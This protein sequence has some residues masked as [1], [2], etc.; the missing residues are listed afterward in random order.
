MSTESPPELLEKPKQ[1]PVPRRS[2]PIEEPPGR[3]S[4]RARLLDGGLIALFLTLTFLLGAFPLKDTDFYW[5]L[6]TGDWIRQTG[7]VPRTDLF[8]FSRVGVPWID[9]HWIFQIGISWVYQQGGIVAL[10]VAKCCIT[11]VAMLVLVSARRREWPVWVIV[12]AW[13]PALLV[14]GGRMYVRPETLTLLYLSLFLAIL[15]RWDRHPLLAL[16]FLPVIQVAWVNSH[17]L[18]VLGPIVLVF[19]LIDAALRFGFFDPERKKWWRTILAATLLTGA[20][21]FVNPYF[22]T[23]ALYPLELA[24]TM[25]NPIFSRNIAELKPI[26]D[27]IREAGGAGFWILQIQLHFAT[28]LLGALSF[29]VP[30]VWLIIVRVGDAREPLKSGATPAQ[31]IRE[32]AKKEKKNSRPKTPRSK[33][34]KGKPPKATTTATDHPSG[35][36]L[37]PFRLLLYAAFSALSFQATRNSH[38]FAAVVGTITAWNFGEWA[39]A[40]RARRLAR[41]AAGAI[42]SSTGP[43]LA[44][45]GAVGLVFLWVGSGVFFKMT[46]EGR[47]IGLGEEPVF[48][49]HAAAKFA[50][51]P[52]MPARFLSFHNGHASLFEYYHGP[53]RKVY[54]D[55]RLEVAGVDL[56]ERYTML[57]N[58]LRMDESGWETE[59]DNMG[60]PVIMVDH[61]YNWQIG[62][63]LFRSNHWRCVW[64]DPIVAVFVHDASTP[65]ARTKA[66]DLAARHFRPD[67]TDESRSVAEL[68]ATTKAYWGYAPAVSPPGGGIGRPFFWLGLDDARRLLRQ[69]PDSATAWKRL[70]QI[71]MLRELRS[72]N[73]PRFRVPFD[74]VLDL[75]IVR[76]TY[77][78][79]RADELAPN[80]FSTLLSL[81]I[82]YESRLMY[83][84]ALPILNRLASLLTTN[85]HQAGEQ[86]KTKAARDKYLEKLG[87]P[88]TTTWRNL[89]ELDQIVSD[90]LGAGRAEGAADLLEKT[91]PPEK[92][93][94]EMID[95]MA[96]LRLH[97]G[98]PARARD[99]WQKATTVPRLGVRD[100]RIAT[101]YLVEGDFDAA[102][103][104]YDKAIESDPNLFE[105]HYCLAVLE[106]DAGNAQAA[107]DQALLALAAAKDGISQSAARA[108][109]NAV[110]RFARPLPGTL[111]P[112]PR[113]ETT[114]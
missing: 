15:F 88:P 78:L 32:T 22:I 99:L 79:R 104:H 100:A 35:W 71:E 39:A 87:T 47:V 34:A 58:R 74:P 107:H 24:G 101:T 17:G 93:S 110:A 59:L 49:A 66:V 3:S 83:E 45:L 40:V 62:A 26:P 82:T 16:L 46:G 106:Q 76:A 111:Q 53:D 70:G 54:T 28:M 38:Q 80:D 75:S 68:T 29:L 7:W 96:T 42:G 31:E 60:R 6:R 52:G 27:F 44:A 37:S 50:G 4:W 92:A 85:V 1:T 94:W 112:P 23:G 89:S 14:L 90:M 51:E 10:T 109:A 77:A 108:I 2:T 65:F 21:C 95:K 56:F 13:L 91:Y 57:G 73:A 41:G 11:C 114:F 36:R 67:P 48:F 69:V 63:T 86:A 97:L 55:P 9:L 25:G 12:L 103:R 64:F 84:A 20:A 18:F 33:T 102:R 30:L 43:R 5:H 19:G 8:T 98:E 61:E 113:A 72:A 81:Q 105:P